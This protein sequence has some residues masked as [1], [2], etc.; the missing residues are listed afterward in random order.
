MPART[1]RAWLVLL[2]GLAACNPFGPP[3]SDALPGPCAPY[4]YNQPWPQTDTDGTVGDRGHY[5][6]S[7]IS[8]VSADIATPVAAGTQVSLHITPIGSTPSPMYVRSTRP[9]IART[10]DWTAA[11]AGGGFQLS[12]YAAGDTKIEVFDSEGLTIDSI[13]VT[14]ANVDMLAFAGDWHG[15]PGPTLIA[16]VGQRLRL[17]LLQ[18]TTELV[19]YG[20]ATFDLDGV[21]ATTKQGQTP[22][23]A[24]ANTE[25]VFL[26]GTVTGG[27]AVTAS[28]GSATT[29]LPITVIAATELT[30][31]E[32]A[33]HAPENTTPSCAI[34][35]A[36]TLRAGATEV[37]GPR[38]RWS[39]T[40]GLAISPYLAYPWFDEGG[41]PGDHPQQQ[42]LFVTGGPST[43]TPHC[44]IGELDV[45]VSITLSAP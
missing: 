19:G 33:L 25:E 12:T 6:F 1:S 10:G 41:W 3:P 22:I 15:Q 23:E 29:R 8:F 17:R 11:L 24:L 5:R 42:Y 37:F 26:V 35:A 44:H 34:V 18:G 40:D 36:M 39:S 21:L 4:N 28:V 20:V 38:C 7:W 31:L 14:V 45:P 27:G 16:G 13:T 30:H 2:V 43:Y 32:V 9:E